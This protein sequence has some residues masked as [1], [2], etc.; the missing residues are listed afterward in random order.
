[1]NLIDRI[2][3]F[4]LKQTEKERESYYPSEI[5]KC[6]R[7]LYYKWIKQPPSNEMEAGAYW[8]MQMGNKI[9]DLIHDFLNDTGLE[10]IPEISFKKDVDLNYP[11]SGRIDNLF[12]DEDSK[13]AGI[14]VKTSYG[15]GIKRLQTAQNPRSED[16]MQVIVYMGCIPEI[17]RFYLLY[18]GRDNAYRTQFVIEKETKTPWT[19]DK[20]LNKF[21]ELEDCVFTMRLPEREYDVAI[22][23]GEIKK[24]FQ[25]NGVIY[26]SDWQCMYCR[27]RDFCWED[28]I[29]E[30]K[31]NG[32]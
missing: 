10:I 4:L 28:E 17:D 11:I 31:T 13:L 16:L 2:D 6:T 26:T 7:Q 1:M 21:R 27:Y 25:A 22:K 19:F 12:I 20:L 24:K 23:N 3:Q 5:S 32:K 15:A 18:V 29:W 30:D 9:H 14:E 8:K